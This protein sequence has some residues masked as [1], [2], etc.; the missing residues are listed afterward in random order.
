MTTTAQATFTVLNHE[1][2]TDQ[3]V[4]IANHGM[5][6]GVSGFI[7]STEL[8]ELFEEHEEEIFNYLDAT[9]FDLGEPSG[10]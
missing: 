7:Y 5:A 2:E 3:L 9:A 10:I 1:F 4:D 6:G 8:A